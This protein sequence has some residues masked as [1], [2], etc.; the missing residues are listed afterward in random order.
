MCVWLYNRCELSGCRTIAAASAAD[1]CLYPVRPA[2]LAVRPRHARHR[3][4]AVLGVL[5][6]PDKFNIACFN[7]DIKSVDFAKFLKSI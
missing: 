1:H 7:R 3:R 6:F 4:L 5:A 2:S